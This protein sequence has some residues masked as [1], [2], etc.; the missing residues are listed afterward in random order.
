MID[1]ATGMKRGER[2]CVENVERAHQFPG[3]FQDGKYYL[4]PELLTAVGWL[5]G[6]RFIYDSLDAEGEPVFADRVAGTIE[7]LALKLVDGTA[8]QLS[9]MEDSA[10]FEP[11]TQA[12]PP[13][14][15]APDQSLPA[16]VGWRRLN[17]GKL[18]LVGAAVLGFVAGFLITGVRRKR[19]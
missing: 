11:V 18:I 16:S 8:L 15:T 6:T 14:V 1:P 2:Y 9:P 3:F 12:M 7:G 10:T 19:R 17:N 4:G 13:A 5:E